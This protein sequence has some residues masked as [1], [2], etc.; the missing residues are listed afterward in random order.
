MLK[1]IYIIKNNKEG[2][3]GQKTESKKR[4]WVIKWSK[5]FDINHCIKSKWSL[6][7]L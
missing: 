7:D 2:T 6:N 1:F 5:D 3:E 4:K